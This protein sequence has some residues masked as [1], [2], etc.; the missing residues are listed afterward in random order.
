MPF[1][2]P[3]FMRYPHITAQVAHH[4]LNALAGS[5][6]TRSGVM[7]KPV[8]PVQLSLL[9]SGDVVVIAWP[10]FVVINQADFIAHELG[11]NQIAVKSPMPRSK[12]VC[13]G[14]IGS[15]AT[16]V[17][18]GSAAV[19]SCRYTAPIAGVSKSHSNSCAN[20]SASLSWRS[21]QVHLR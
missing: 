6:F 17:I 5:H 12:K 11:A 18:R 16:L 14:S 9:H 19:I 20:C 15:Y 2:G 4:F 3:M 8:W 10:L 1:S 7:W 13:T 21:L